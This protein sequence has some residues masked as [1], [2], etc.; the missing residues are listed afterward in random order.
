MRKTRPAFRGE[1]LC[2]RTHPMPGLHC[3]PADADDPVQP[4][5]VVNIVS[6]SI[7]QAVLINAVANNVDDEFRVMKEGRGHDDT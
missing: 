5:L 3:A 7:D 2:T 6:H 4:N 1:P